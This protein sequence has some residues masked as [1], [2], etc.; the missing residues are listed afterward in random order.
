MVAGPTSFGPLRP[1]PDGDQIVEYEQIPQAFSSA[2]DKVVWQRYQAQ[3]EVG[4]SLWKMPATRRRLSD[5]VRYGAQV[6]AICRVVMPALI[7]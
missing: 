1:T 4:I 6:S 5:M 2:G 7:A 3:Q